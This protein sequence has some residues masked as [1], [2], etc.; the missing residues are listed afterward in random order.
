VFDDGGTMTFLRDGNMLV[1]QMSGQGANPIYASSPTTFHPQDIEAQ[2]EF[3][4]PVEGRSPALTMQQDGV[5]YRA[6]RR[7]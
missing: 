4:P 1:S 7:E 6:I 2:I 3:D 5:I